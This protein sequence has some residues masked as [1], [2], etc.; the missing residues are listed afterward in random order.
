MHKSI[1]T[2]IWVGS[3]VVLAVVAVSY[4]FLVPPQKRTETD[5]PVAATTS[6]VPN[7]AQYQSVIAKK[8][9]F[10]GYLKPEIESQNHEILLARSRLLSIYHAHLAAT[11]DRPTQTSALINR[12]DKQFV[13]D[14]CVEYR[15]ACGPTDTTDILVA[16]F[17]ELIVRVD[18]IPFELVLV[19]AANES[20][21]GT[22]R[23]ARQGYNF[24]GLWCFRK[25]C[26]F[27]P[28]RRDQGSHHEVAKFNS[29]TQGVAR[30]L[31]NLNR[32][33]AYAE[34]RQ[35]RATLRRTQQPLTAELLVNGL[36][37]YSERGQAYI[38]ELQA[39]IRVNR[40]Y[41]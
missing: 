31:N 29:L 34:L 15:V 7:F 36:L 28:R 14:L 16:S 1:R 13:L 38:D 17:A 39:M 19:Q 12:E 25:G 9:A 5:V 10:F 20:A 35:I 37:S 27:V 41:M 11:G 6:A 3:V 22:S 18:I 26:G 30:Y 23:F 21:W 40:V 8:R 4:P 24:F 33:P 2:R 32:H